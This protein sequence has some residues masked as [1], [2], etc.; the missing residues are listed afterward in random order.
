[1]SSLQKFKETMEEFDSEVE[2]LK[3]VSDA[4]QKLQ[5]LA[6][7]YDGIS[8]QFDENSKNLD[9]INESQKTQQ[10][11]VV[12]SLHEIEGVSKQSKKELASIIE[13]GADLIRKENKGFYRELE[14]TIQIKLDDN[15]SQIKQ[16]IESERFQIKQIIEIEFAKNTKE[17]SNVFETLTNRQTQ[18]I[19]ES[20]KII[21]VSIWVIGAII[22]LLQLFK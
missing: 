16:L 10:A 2:K 17:L 3:A 5:G 19:L 12:Q 7:S 20:H 8:K 13:E 1:M 11:K 15:R 22:I 14:S 9:K 4:Y 6:V 18:E 21:K